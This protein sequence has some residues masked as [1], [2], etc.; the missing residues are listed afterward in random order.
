MN[1][2]PTIAR[3]RRA[4]PPKVSVVRTFH[5]GSAALEAKAVVGADVK[6]FPPFT[7]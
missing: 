3:C 5:G 6:S 7:A 1:Q 4:V 2:F